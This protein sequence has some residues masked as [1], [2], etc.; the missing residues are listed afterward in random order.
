MA[1]RSLGRDA[2]LEPFSPGAPE[3]P[4]PRATPFRADTFALALPP[5]WTDAS[6]VTLAGPVCDGLAHAV[7]VAQAPH[8]GRTLAAVADEQVR[9]V[10]ATL[11]NATLLTRDAV[12]CAD[13]TPAERAIFRWSPAPE[14]VL[15]QQQVYAVVGERVLTLAATFTARSRRVL[16]PEVQR[17]MLSLAAEAPAEPMAEPT[18]SPLARL[19]R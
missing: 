2:R 1:F 17:L 15:Y 14:R 7:T 8:D 4:A 12:A 5:G 13:G 16:G 9:A 10:L 3:R 19:G 18:P 6:I 11:R